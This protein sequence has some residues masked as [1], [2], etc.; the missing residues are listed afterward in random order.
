M[1]ALAP[2]LKNTRVPVYDSGSTTFPKIRETL[3]G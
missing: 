2:F 3:A 1:S